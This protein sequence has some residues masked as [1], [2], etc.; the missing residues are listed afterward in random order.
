MPEY[1]VD[2]LGRLGTSAPVQA[3]PSRVVFRVR[4]SEDAEAGA[5]D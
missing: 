4:Q 1:S 5:S 2:Y 3:G